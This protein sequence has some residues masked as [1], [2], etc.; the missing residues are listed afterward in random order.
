MAQPQALK[1]WYMGTLGAVARDGSAADVWFDDGD[2]K[3]EHGV[4]AKHIRLPQ[5]KAAK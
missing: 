4:L 2:P 5:G 1:T 3:V